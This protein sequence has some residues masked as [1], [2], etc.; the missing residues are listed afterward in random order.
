[1][2]RT[3]AETGIE[4]GT[5]KVESEIDETGTVLGGGVIQEAEVEVGIA[6]IVMGKNDARDIVEVP[7]QESMV[8]GLKMALVM[9]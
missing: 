3:M 8:M 2:K 4:I 7:A 1:M 6:K 9:T 5:G